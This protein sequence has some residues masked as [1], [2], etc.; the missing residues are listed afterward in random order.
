M[1]VT[2]VRTDITKKQVFDRFHPFGDI[3]QVGLVQNSAL[4]HFRN[5][6]DALKAMDELNGQASSAPYFLRV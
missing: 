2:N 4:V 5:R 1:Y 6:E 3:D